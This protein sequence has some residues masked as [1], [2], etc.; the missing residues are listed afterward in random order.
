MTKGGDYLP[1]HD[2]KTLSAII[3][4]VGGVKQLRQLV[5]VVLSRRIEVK[6]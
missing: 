1:G 5:E 3:E 4:S 6:L 2:S